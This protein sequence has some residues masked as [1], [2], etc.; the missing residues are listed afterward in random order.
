MQQNTISGTVAKTNLQKPT[1]LRAYTIRAEKEIGKENYRRRDRS[2]RA[3][4]AK[5]HEGRL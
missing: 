4:L 5:G 3:R 1:Y 2:Y